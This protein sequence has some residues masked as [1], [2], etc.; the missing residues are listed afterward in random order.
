MKTNSE[1]KRQKSYRIPEALKNEV[2]RQIGK[3][4]NLEIMEHS[5]IKYAQ[6][7]FFK[8]KKSPFIKLCVDY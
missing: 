8:A 7:I 5:E 3:L 1:T 6:P 4:F 2:D